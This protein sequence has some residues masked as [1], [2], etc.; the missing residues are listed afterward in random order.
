MRGLKL[1]AREG[2]GVEGWDRELGGVL[3]KAHGPRP[4]SRALKMSFALYIVFK[5]FLP[6]C[7]RSF[8][9]VIIVFV[10]NCL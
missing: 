9:G 4:I 1:W 5:C 7:S 8:I 10:F 6:L 2:V 3:A